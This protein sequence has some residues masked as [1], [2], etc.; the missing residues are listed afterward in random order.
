[1]TALLF[2]WALE[3]LTFFW[4]SIARAGVEPIGRSARDITFVNV[5]FK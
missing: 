4:G 5:G 1:M 2:R 3:H